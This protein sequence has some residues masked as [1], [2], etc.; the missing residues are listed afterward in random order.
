MLFTEKSTVSPF[1]SY[2]NRPGK[3]RVL[4]QHQSK[5][6][7]ADT[8]AQPRHS[9]IQFVAPDWCC[10]DPKSKSTKHRT[11]TKAISGVSF[12][13]ALPRW[14]SSAVKENTLHHANTQFTTGD[15][16][17]H[18]VTW[19]PRNIQKLRENILDTRN[20][21]RSARLLSSLLH[22]DIQS[23][24]KADLRHAN[25]S[26]RAQHYRKQICQL[27]LTM[28]TERALKL[29]SKED[30]NLQ[31][32]KQNLNRL[33]H[34]TET[35]SSLLLAELCFFPLHFHSRFFKSPVIKG[36][37]SICRHSFKYLHQ[38]S[39]F[40]K[41]VSASTLTEKPH[42]EHLHVR[43]AGTEDAAIGEG[44]M[45]SIGSA[46]EREGL[47]GT[48]V[49]HSESDRQLRKRRGTD[50]KTEMGRFSGTKQTVCSAWTSRSLHLWKNSW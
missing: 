15:G 5:E 7:E 49:F 48:R 45:S 10:L 40:L 44:G 42:A 26:W 29:S 14:N 20:S 13:K 41:L 33:V 31:R 23:L 46:E 2:V 16:L 27:T 32:S 21:Q 4:C 39:M 19:R 9:T 47:Q 38:L 8:G 34:T 24:T 3:A 22:R 11:K 50:N 43:W 1:H 30:C 12:L 18:C 37:P 36:I 6:Y 25:S 35:N 28:L 17:H